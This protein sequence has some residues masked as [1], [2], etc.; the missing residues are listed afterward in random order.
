[1]Y[2]RVVTQQKVS[3]KRLAIDFQG[4]VRW[5]FNGEFGQGIIK[6]KTTTQAG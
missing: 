3:S 5:E 6:E 4:G 1:M 2:L